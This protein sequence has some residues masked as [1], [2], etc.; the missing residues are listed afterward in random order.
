MYYR[1][2][3]AIELAEKTETLIVIRSIRKVLKD[4]RAD[5][6]ETF[7]NTVKFQNSN[8]SGK[9]RSN[10][11]YMTRVNKGTFTVINEGNKTIVTYETYTSYLAY[12]LIFV[13]ICF[14]GLIGL[15]IFF[16]GILL[17]GFL[18]FTT[19]LSIKNGGFGLINNVKK[20]I[21]TQFAND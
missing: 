3:T 19:Y 20:N 13:L 21:D 11:S 12:L 9:C 16:I 10:V 8:F 15:D 18:V 17:L 4:A 14:T 7:D 2:K 1:F 6:Y 5:K